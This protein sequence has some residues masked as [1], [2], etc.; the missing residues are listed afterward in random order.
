MSRKD[1]VALA[2]SLGQTIRQTSDDDGRAN[3]RWAAHNI[4]TTLKAEQPRFDYARFMDFVDDVAAGTR[5]LDGK[6]VKP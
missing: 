6:V 5:G 2:I 4:A 1:Y 3:V